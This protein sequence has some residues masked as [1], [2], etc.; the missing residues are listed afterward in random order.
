MHSERVRLRYIICLQN[1]WAEI[2]H[3]PSERVGRDISYAFRM[4]G[5][6]YIIC[7]QNG[8]AEIYHMPSEWVGQDISTPLHSRS[9]RDTGYIHP[10]F[11]H[12]SP[13][14]ISIMWLHSNLGPPD[15]LA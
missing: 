9:A 3:M 8:W 10:P 5:P 13:H 12:V 11:Q 2:Y 14:I 7:L 6:R 15:T 4:G 1:G